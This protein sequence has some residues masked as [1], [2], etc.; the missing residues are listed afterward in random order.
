MAELSFHQAGLSSVELWAAFRQER[1]RVFSVPK[2]VSCCNRRLLCRPLGQTLVSKWNPTVPE[3]PTLSAQ[4][5][6][7][8]GAD[9]NKGAS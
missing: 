6:A 8:G 4:H 7:L 2:T 9:L 1:E 5:V 3:I